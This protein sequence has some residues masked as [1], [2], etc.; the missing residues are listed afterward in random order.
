MNLK[1]AFRFQNK[2]QAFLEEG[3]RIL[4]RESNIT[5]VENTYLRRK[6]MAEAQN[7]TVLIAP[8]TDYYDRITDVARFLVWLLEQKEALYAAIREAKAAQT[9]DIDSEVSLNACRQ[10]V[11]QTFRQMNGLRASEQIISGGGTGYRFNADGNQVSYRCD[12][13]RVT[14][15][16]FDRSVIRRELTRL[17][18][19]ADE[20]SAA[21]DLCTV[22]AQVDFRPPFNVNDSFDD[23]FQ[24]FLA[25]TGRP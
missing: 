16:N 23:A 5:R 10:S 6:V 22:T 7:E 4:S 14:T 9:I 25:D 21:L 17:N 13:K 18:K 1:E 24:G 15:I 12:V 20:T 11:A 2:L 3:Q 19:K 8:E